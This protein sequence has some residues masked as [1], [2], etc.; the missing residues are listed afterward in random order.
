MFKK[1]KLSTLPPYEKS[2]DLTNRFA[3]KIEQI[4]RV[5]LYIAGQITSTNNYNQPV[6][7]NIYEF[8]LDLTTLIFGEKLRLHLT[9]LRGSFMLKKGIILAGGH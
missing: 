6:T 8:H 1:I 3:L 2:H 7:Y 9:L 5:F 4:L